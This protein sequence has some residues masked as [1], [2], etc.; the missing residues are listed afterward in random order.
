MTPPADG[1]PALLTHREVETIFHEFGHLL[2]H[3]LGEVEIKSLNGVNV[4]W[5][6]VEL[7]SQIMENWTWE[8]ESLDL[9]ARH[10]ET[11]APIPET[12]YGKMIA[13]K[14]F[15]SAAATMRQVAFAKMDLLLH[16]RTG[17]FASEPDVEPKV[18]ALIADCLVPT[19]PPAPTIVKRFTH[20][21]SD[22]VGYAAGYYSYKWAEVLDADAFTRFKREGIFNPTVGSEFV[23]KILSRGNSADPAELYRA[24]MGREPDLNALLQRSGLAPAA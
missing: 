5:D 16:M 2:H 9:F 21:F 7:P 15:R 14:N 23:D 20:V 4:A 19:E 11:G 22:P 10:H 6:F 24:F 8:R 1:R 12:I 13:A 18:R 17:E 3:L